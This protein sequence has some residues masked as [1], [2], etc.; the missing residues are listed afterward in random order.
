MS[1]S[2]LFLSAK[3]SSIALSCWL[4]YSSRILYASRGFLAFH[5]S[6]SNSSLWMLL[7]L[8]NASNH[9]CVAMNLVG[10][11]NA[12]LRAS[13]DSFCLRLAS[14]KR[15]CFSSLFCFLLFKSEFASFLRFAKSWSCFL[16]SSSSF[17]ALSFCFCFSLTIFSASVNFFF[18]I[19]ICPGSN[20]FFLKSTSLSASSAAFWASLTFS[21]A[22]FLAFS[23]AT[24]SLW[25]WSNSCSL[26]ALS[27]SAFFISFFTPSI[28]SG[29]IFFPSSISF[30][31]ESTFFSNSFF[32]FWAVAIS[33]LLTSTSLVLLSISIFLL[34]TFFFASNTCSSETV[35][36]LSCL[37]LVSTGTSAAWTCDPV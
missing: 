12:F 26:V 34:S 18:A 10:Y 29:V 4:K 15:R 17:W 21:S 3:K 8:L 22:V 7:N 24:L 35:Y 23:L 2:R 1:S 13:S 25:A 27:V 28:T 37:T 32:S 20:A 14:S 9:S 31:K 33:F 5:A 16:P 19:S 36:V 11:G 6:K 30:T